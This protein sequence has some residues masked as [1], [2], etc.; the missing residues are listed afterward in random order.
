M[1]RPTLIFV[2]LAG[3]TAVLEPHCLVADID[4]PL[5]QK[6]FD[7]PQRERNPD[8]EHHRLADDLGTGFEPLEWT[9]FGHWQTL[10]STL[11]R[12]K[13]SSSDR[14]SPSSVGAKRTAVKTS[15]QG[16]C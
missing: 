8:V 13:P 10:A 14:A 5:M 16:I 15:M 11:P 6:I 3:S 9:V 12:L 7:V 1:T 2:N 4:T